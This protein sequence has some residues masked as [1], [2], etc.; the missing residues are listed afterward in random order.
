MRTLS[1]LVAVAAL[2]VLAATPASAAVPE[3]VTVTFNPMVVCVT[4]PCEQPPP[5]TICVHVPRESPTCTD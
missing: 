2:A 3:I 4:E 1:R 5:V